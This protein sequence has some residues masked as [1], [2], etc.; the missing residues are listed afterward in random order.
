MGDQESNASTSVSLN[1][2][3]SGSKSTSNVRPGTAKKPVANGTPA[4]TNLLM[5]D[6]LKGDLSNDPIGSSLR[7]R[8]NT[9][10]LSATLT[11]QVCR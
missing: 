10:G 2:K 6:G 1:E 9:C 7:D 11:E 5:P 3:E 8:V 4:K